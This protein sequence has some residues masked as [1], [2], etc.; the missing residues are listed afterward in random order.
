[1]TPE[2]YI[3]ILGA[4]SAILVSFIGA[5][6]VNKNNIILQT[7]KLKEEHYVAYIEALHYLAGNNYDSNATEKYVFARN[8]IFIIASEEVVIKMI[9]YEEEAVG[10]QNDLH[11]K[12]LT[13]LIKEI[14]KDL[15]INDKNF[16]RIYLRKA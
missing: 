6:L 16:P 9:K 5:F 2:I 7:K 3:S 15:K 14:R 8:K 11:D 1:M 4:I 10:K 12:Y 13:E